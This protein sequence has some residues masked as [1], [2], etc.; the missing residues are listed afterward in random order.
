MN[1]LADSSANAAM[2]EHAIEAYPE[3]SCGILVRDDRSSRIDTYRYVRVPN[4]H[5]DPREGFEIEAGLVEDAAAVVHSHPSGEAWPSRADMESQIAAGVPYVVV[6]LVTSM[7]GAGNGTLECAG[8][9]WWPDRRERPYLGRPFRHGVSDCYGLVRD[10]YAR[11]RGIELPA[12]AYGWHWEVESPELDLYS[13]SRVELGWR[14][15]EPSS[16]RPGDLL[17]LRI[18]HS[19]V[20]NHAGVLLKGGKVLHHPSMRPYDPT[21][22]SRLSAASR[23]ARFIV[24]VSRPP[25]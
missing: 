16:A 23:L 11:E 25:C 18:G 2:V 8:M 6:P 13:S 9:F 15:I 12:V 4:L 17:L 22:R 7:Y 21:C 19:S 20:A 3:E 5:P 10:W 1:P 14:R 24:E